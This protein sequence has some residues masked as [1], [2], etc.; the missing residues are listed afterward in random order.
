MKLNDTLQ[1]YVAKRHQVAADI[2]HLKL[3]ASDT[4]VQLPAWTPGAHINVHYAPPASRPYSLCNA[5]DENGAYWVAVKLDPQSRGSSSF[6]HQ[7]REGDRLT[8]SHPNNH[9][10]LVPDAKHYVL[11]AGGIGITPLYAMFTKLQAE[12]HPVTLHYFIRDTQAAAFVEP[13]QARGAKIYNG[14]DAVFTYSALT[15]ILTR[16]PDGAVIYAC[17]PAGFLDYVNIIAR[18]QSIPASSLYQER[19]TPAAPSPFNQ[20]ERPKSFE[21]YF[22]QSQKSCTVLPQQSIITAAASVSVQIPH[23]CEMGVCG[24]CVTAVLDG[25]PDHYDEVLT[26]EQKA[27]KAWIVPCISRC[28]S[29]KLVLDC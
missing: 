16:L 26:P 8:I 11:L 13:L 22:A 15:D 17:G 4:H 10:E 19:F 5:P 1:V 9:F 27:S 3:V 29:A 12:Q 6:M 20:A 7:L 28:S 23:S 18:S 24:T 14:L 21:V 2:V 25:E